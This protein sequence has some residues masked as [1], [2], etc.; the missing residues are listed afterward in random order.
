M[1]RDCCEYLG[2]D[3]LKWI[4]KKVGEEAWTVLK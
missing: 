3:G 4:F 2:V 1:E